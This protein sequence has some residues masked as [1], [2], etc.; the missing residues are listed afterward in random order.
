MPDL[1]RLSLERIE[2]VMIAACVEGLQK[3]LAAHL[4]QTELGDFLTAWSP[5][6]LPSA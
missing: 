4:C 3:K 5:G 1:H 6:G 2:P